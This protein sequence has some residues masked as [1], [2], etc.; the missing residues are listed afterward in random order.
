MIK[1]LL[2]VQ[3]VSDA[4]A[5]RNISNVIFQTHPFR[6]RGAIHCG[7]SDPFGRATHTVIRSTVAAI[8]SQGF[9]DTSNTNQI[10]PIVC[11][12]TKQS[13]NLIKKGWWFSSTALRT[14]ILC[15]NIVQI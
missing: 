10:A 9:T 14:R 3:L 12:S 1:S 8:A 5:I 13:V 6:L 2:Q 7:F 15:L 4:N 11:G